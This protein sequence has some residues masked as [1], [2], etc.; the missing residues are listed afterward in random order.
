MDAGNI[1]SLW[2]LSALETL[3]DI[4]TNLVTTLLNPL[5]LGRKEGLPAGRCSPSGWNLYFGLAIPCLFNAFLF[6]YDTTLSVINNETVGTDM[7]RRILLLLCGAAVWYR[8]FQAR[9]YYSK[10]FSPSG[11]S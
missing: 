9:F 11:T 6:Y 3:S 5:N 4:T 7:E 1:L 8:G 10:I 2:V